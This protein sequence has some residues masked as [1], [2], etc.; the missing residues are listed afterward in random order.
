MTMAFDE[1]LTARI[2]DGSAAQ[3]F[4]AEFVDAAGVGDYGSWDQVSSAIVDTVSRQTPGFTGW[5]QESWWTH[6]GDAAGSSANAGRA[7]F[8][9]FA[10]TRT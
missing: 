10:P 1:S 2:A 4:D 5:Q 6:C 8:P 3:Q 9:P 7:R